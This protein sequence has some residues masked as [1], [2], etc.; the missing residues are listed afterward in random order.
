SLV[1]VL[2]GHVTSLQEKVVGLEG[3]VTTIQ[4][5][6]AGL[7]SDNVTL[8]AELGAMA[9]RIN[10]IAADLRERRRRPPH[11]LARLHLQLVRPRGTGQTVLVHRQLDRAD[12]RP[13]PRRPRRPSRVSDTF[14]PSSDRGDMSAVVAPGIAT[15][16][17][18]LAH[19]G[20]G[21]QEGRQRGRRG[22]GRG[23]RRRGRRRKK[24]R[25][26]GVDLSGAELHVRLRVLQCES[27]TPLC[28]P[29]APLRLGKSEG[30]VVIGF[31]A[32]SQH[33]YKKGSAAI[34]PILGGVVLQFVAALLGT[35][36]LASLVAGGGEAFQLQYDYDGLY[37]SVLA[38]LAV[39]LVE[40]LSFVVS[41]LGV[42][43]SGLG[44]PATQSITVIIG[45]SVLFGA[46]LGLL[47]LGDRL[48]VWGWSGWDC[49]WQ[50]LPSW[51]WI[52]GR[53][54]RRGEG[55]CTCQLSRGRRCIGLIC[56]S[57]YAF[58][59]IFIKKGSASI[60]PILGGEFWLRLFGLQNGESDIVYCW[61]VLT[62]SMMPS[63]RPTDWLPYS[64]A[65]CLPPSPCRGPLW[66]W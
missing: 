6:V 47:V 54:W 32:G 33:L 58:Y 41:G 7:K 62:H 44:V 23:Q 20:A 5:E 40:M 14:A 24:R 8:Q 1:D 21:R 19:D 10:D 39:G 63:H 50:A 16:A 2:E 66:R 29:L 26:V 38:G 9:R 13:P 59:N 12:L 52:R 48:V 61:P 11:R 53:R 22:G 55:R 49:S 30:E 60:D 45:G 43:V 65:P 4:E 42:V 57:A 34:N 25:K 56:A 17:H 51:R 3:Q 46:V 27:L 31:A 28:W 18:V 64:G 37:W 35:A 15:V 36:L